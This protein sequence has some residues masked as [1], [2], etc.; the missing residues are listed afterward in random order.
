MDEDDTLLSWLR[1]YVS[2]LGAFLLLGVGAA[3]L[4]LGLTPKEF[5]AWSIVV[6][7][8]LRIPPRQVG[9]FAEAIFRSGAVHGPA[10]EALGIQEDP[11]SFLSNSADIRP[12]P[13]TN[14]V[15]IIG[16]AGD[17]QRAQEISAAMA[18]S[19]VDAVEAR[20]ELSEFTVFDE[21]RTVPAQ[22]EV[23]VP[24][25]LSVGG[26]AAFWLALGAS[27]L[28]YR[29]RRPVL[30][31]VRAKHILDP[32]RVTSLDGSWPRWLGI[33]RPKLR[34]SDSESNRLKLALVASNGAQPP[35]VVAPGATARTLKLL[36]RRLPDG[37]SLQ[38]LHSQP[39]DP[40]SERDR[41]GVVVAHAST[42]EMDLEQTDFAD[43]AEPANDRGRRSIELLWVR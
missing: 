23:S 3:A 26:A 17:S 18:E 30:G 1:Y 15:I 43:R 16:R 31:V 8:G 19:F 35:L 39:T 5:E 24:V 32:A 9:A 38:G 22:G 6:E 33:F 12:V 42:G 7:D 28:H 2:L 27:L 37:W 21:A 25:G 10:M 40:L 4:Y 11:R 13:D 34:W 29:L 20:I 41:P 14:V 36:A